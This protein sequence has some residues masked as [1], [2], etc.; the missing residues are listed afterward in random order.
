M[1]HLDT[2]VSLAATFSTNV[3]VVGNALSELSLPRSLC[4]EPRTCTAVKWADLDHWDPAKISVWDSLLVSVYCNHI[5]PSALCYPGIVIV[6]TTKST[7]FRYSRSIV[8]RGLVH[9]YCWR[10]AHH[11]ALENVATRSKKNF[12]FSGL[13]RS[14]ADEVSGDEFCAVNLNS[15]EHGALF[16]SANV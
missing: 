16:H 14:E 6:W 15:T 5:V 2:L 1:I 13:H 8:T 4:H 10:L 12:W 11:V 7:S 9:I 3:S